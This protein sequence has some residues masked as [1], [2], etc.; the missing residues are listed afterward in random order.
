MAR[1]V[2]YAGKSQKTIDDWTQDVREIINTNLQGLQSSDANSFSDLPDW[3]NNGS[4]SDKKLS[5]AKLEGARQ[6]T[7][8][9]KDS[10]RVVYIADFEEVIVVLHC[11]KKK[12]EGKQSKDMKTVESRLKDAKSVFGRVK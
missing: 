9:Y 4:T 11:F 8:K 6:L 2:V 7:I 3:S 12:T 1:D 10:Y 5:G